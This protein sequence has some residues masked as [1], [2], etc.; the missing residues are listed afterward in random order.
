MTIKYQ[1]VD[2]EGYSRGVFK[3]RDEAL[4]A[5]GKNGFVR[6]VING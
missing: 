4:K 5:A 3:T 6:Q 1:A 2:H